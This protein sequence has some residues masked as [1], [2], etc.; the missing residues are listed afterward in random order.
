M[1][2]LAKVPHRKIVLNEFNGFFVLPYVVYLYLDL[3]LYFYMYI[4]TYIHEYLCKYTH[5]YIYTYTYYVCIIYMYIF[6]PRKNGSLKN[7]WPAVWK[8]AVDESQ[9]PSI[10]GERYLAVRL[11]TAQVEV[12]GSKPSWNTPF[13]WPISGHLSGPSFGVTASPHGRMP[14][15]QPLRRIWHAWWFVPSLR[16]YVLSP[17]LWAPRTVP[18]IQLELRMGIGCTWAQGSN[19]RG[20]RDIQLGSDPCCLLYCFITLDRASVTSFRTWGK[21]Y[22]PSSLW[23]QMET[24]RGN[25]FWRLWSSNFKLN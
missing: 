3:Y 10:G 8:C 25:A 16:D 19:R 11:E 5:I 1:K 14:C 7:I 23:D 21:Q 24:L 15:W 13:V 22:L 17:F 2:K 4:D 12:L 20:F 6:F 9:E 18:G